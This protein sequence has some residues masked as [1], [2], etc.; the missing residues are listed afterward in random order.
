M[1]TFR[2]MGI[3]GGVVTVLFSATLAMAQTGT[4]TSATTNVA[5]NPTLRATMLKEQ[6]E[7]MKARVDV[8]ASSTAAR[9]EEGKARIKEQ[10]TK[11]K[12]RI[13]EN[14]KKVAEL[15]NKA[16]ARLAEIKDKEKKNL[17]DKLHNEFNRINKIETS[18][19][20]KV[21]SQ[22]NDVLKKV[23]DRATKAA[24]NGK[25]ITAVTAAIESAKTAIAVAQIAVTA[26]AAKTYVLNTTAIVA[27]STAA[28]TT[29]D[30]Q[31]Q[32]MKGLRTAFQTLHE[33]LKNDLKTI[34]DGVI[35]DARKAVQGA[36]QALG[37]VSQGDDK[38]RKATS[39]AP[40]ATTTTT[41]TTTN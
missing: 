21:L 32:L 27:T 37:P 14:K 9:M 13:E 28:T 15:Q 16:K 4:G 30:G 2:N 17:A 19:F 36:I 12:A 18:H 7:K 25:D 26:Q 8:R 34:R 6:E 40:T 41:A 3:V 24:A 31:E 33:E 35:K 10:E 38:D 5:P 23:Q 11:A 39:T 29:R 22:Y 1:H 20:T